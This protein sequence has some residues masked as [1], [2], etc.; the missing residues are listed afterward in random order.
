MKG[1]SGTGNNCTLNIIKLENPTG[2]WKTSWLFTSVAEE[3]NSWLL[4][5][6]FS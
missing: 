5:N 6:T 4:K 1:F 2:G 3:P